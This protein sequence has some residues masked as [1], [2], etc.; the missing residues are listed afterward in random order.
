[1]SRIAR[2]TEAAR[3]M[4]AMKQARER[5]R[6]PRERLR[7]HQSAALDALVRDV[8]ARSPFYRERFA[9]LVGS[10]PVELAAL[11]TVDKA[12]LMANLDDALCE[13]RLRGRD[14]RAHVLDEALLLGEFRVLASSGSTGTPSLY[15]YSRS[16]WTGILALFFRMNEMSGIR[17]ASRAPGSLRSGPLRSRA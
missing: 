15:I 16:D 13:P 9:G 7:A 11:P 17:P 6:W 4:R 10:G 14:L 8:L 1:M 2:M 5:E 3:G 12:T